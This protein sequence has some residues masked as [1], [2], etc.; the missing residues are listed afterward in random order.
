[1]I[2]S[3]KQAKGT[4]LL[5]FILTVL[6]MS[7]ERVSAEAD[8]SIVYVPQDS[9]TIQEA[10]NI[11]N[12]GGIIYVSPGVYFESFTVDKDGIRIVGEDKATTT[13]DLGSSFIQILAENTSIRGFS[14]RSG[15]PYA[16]YIG[17]N[18][19]T[20]EDNTFESNYGAIYC[21]YIYGTRM[22]T[23][24]LIVG[25]DF[26][27]NSGIALYLKFAC[28]N[29][30][31]GNNFTHNYWA[32]T[33]YDGSGNNIISR[34]YLYDTSESCINVRESPETIIC[35]NY[36]NSGT[37]GIYVDTNSDNTTVSENFLVNIRR[38]W[39]TIYII[40]SKNVIT[41]NNYLVNN[42]GGIY[43]DHAANIFLSNNTMQNNQYGL[44]INGDELYHFVHV[45]DHSNKINGKPIYYFVNEK[46]LT[47][48]PSH[49]SE[50][51]SLIIVNSTD[52]KIKDL[53]IS[54]NWQGLL[55]A[56]T[57]NSE[58]ANVTV[59]RN[60]YGIYLHGSSNNTFVGNNMLN[61]TYGMR[62]QSNSIDTIYK[63]N[64]INNTS[65]V[66]CFS[67]G[68]IWDNGAEG[69]FWSDYDGEDS[70]QDGIYDEPYMINTENQDSFPLVSPFSL[71]RRFYCGTWDQTPYYVVICSNSTVAGFIFEPDLK[72]ICFNVTGPS[73]TKGFC[74]VTVPKALLNGIYEVSEDDSILDFSIS[75]NGSCSFVYFMYNH[76][77]RY[78]KITGTTA[79]PEFNMPS[80][81]LVIFLMFTLLSFLLA[82]RKKVRQAG[83]ITA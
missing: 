40:N 80:L 73:G 81:L 8:H 67:Q 79:I 41:E 25:N 10:L 28:S 47:I 46:E 11:V 77:T 63:N 33:L 13:I 38:L 72:K 62:L 27:N 18:G 37:A 9:P 66:S 22:V 2:S 58:V 64:F 83:V 4:L 54:N 44:G 20:V 74:N 12:S 29:V 68:S 76:S 50:I 15:Y 65:Q 26:R 23:N 16:L 3:F 56:Y 21:G 1:M 45:I 70:N 42:S 75:S 19:T 49:F 48:N 34:N 24:N 14:I 53:Q 69:N 82:L 78:V 43:L 55:L 61:N 17:S 35:R 59:S 51:G 32:I 30:I 5:L 7:G 71:S 36:V 6:L 52:I 39:G 60:N 57:E 31:T